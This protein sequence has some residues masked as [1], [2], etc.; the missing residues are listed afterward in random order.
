MN[1]NRFFRNIALGIENLLL[2]KLR[3]VL[4]ML[5]VVFGVGSVVAMLSVGEGASQEAMDQIRKLGSTNII[6]T[7]VKP[8]DEDDRTAPRSF[9]SMSMY[10]LTYDDYERLRVSYPAV[11]QIAPVKLLRKESRLGSRSM[12]LRVVGT[13]DAWFDLV[14]RELIAGRRLRA[15]DEDQ[16]NPVAVLTEF[17]ARRLLATQSTIGQRVRIGGQA[18]EIVGIIKS[19]SGQAGEMQ[20]PDRDVDVY[21]PLRIARDYFGD[22]TTRIQAGSMS[23]ERVELHQIIAQIDEMGNVEPTAAAIEQMLQRFHRRKSYEISVP[24]SLLRQAEATQRTFN[25]VLGSIAGISLLVGGIGIMNIMLASV[26][27]RTRE[28]GIRRAIGAKRGQIITQFLIETIVLST[29]GGLVGIAL[30]VLTPMLIT[31]FSGMPTVLT[32]LSIVLPMVISFVVG[33]VFGLYPAANAA[34][35][36]PIIALRHE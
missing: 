28:I 33:I 11:R 32:P 16:F 35:V 22:T 8:V 24:L 30:G 6:L 18:F 20:V 10:G 9:M 29:I 25:I 15:S 3:S 19:E 23:R 26:T 14:Q 17:G 12:E 27:E 7:S 4:T 1:Q 5:G 21:I 2:H 31:Y 36:D 34:R 13:S